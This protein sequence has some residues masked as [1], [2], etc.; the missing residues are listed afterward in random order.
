M[1]TVTQLKT[2]LA[3]ALATISGLR[4]YA[5]QPDQVNPPFA[6]PTLESIHYHDAMGAGLQTYEFKVTCV[7]GRSS[8]RSAQNTL[9]AYLSYTGVRAALE[10]DRTLGGV[11][12]SLIVESASNIGTIDAN[13]GLYLFVD[14]RVII[15]AEG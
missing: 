13:D 4:T 3:S 15:Y 10:A 9:D 12:D 1:A 5:Y 8:E 2:G 6:W 11:C 14:Y 7:V